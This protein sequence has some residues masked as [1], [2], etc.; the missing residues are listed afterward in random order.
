MPRIK[1]DNFVPNDQP[2]GMDELNVEIQYSETERTLLV[3]TNGAELVF[4]GDAYAFF[5]KSRKENGYNGVHN[6]E[7]SMLVEDVTFSTVFYGTI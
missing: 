3:D 4:T 7:L 6:I 1:I 5:V 2:K